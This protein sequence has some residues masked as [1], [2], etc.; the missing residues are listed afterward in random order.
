[1]TGPRHV[2]EILRDVVRNI[3]EPSPATTLMTPQIG[4]FYIS[5]F[6]K[7]TVWLSRGDG[8]GMG[9]SN[10]CFEELLAGLYWETF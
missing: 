7:K 3:P 8:E 5:I 10:E 9:A 2:R 4:D 1:M 6:D